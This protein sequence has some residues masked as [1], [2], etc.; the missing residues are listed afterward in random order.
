M[1]WVCEQRGARNVQRRNIK[2]DSLSPDTD[3]LFDIILLLGHNMG[4]GET[5]EGVEQLLA[6]CHQMTRPGGLLL[7]NSI[8]VDLAPWAKD[9]VANNTKA[10]RYVGETQYQIRFGPYLGHPFGWIHVKPDD[11][12]VWARQNGFAP[13]RVVRSEGTEHPGCWAGLY[14]RI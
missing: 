10:G 8:D 9:R 12:D 5:T 11:F 14:Q 6:T 4:L 2:L 13:V 1:C 3:G 7:V